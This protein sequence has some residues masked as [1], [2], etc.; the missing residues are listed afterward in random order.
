MPG[1]VG[2]SRRRHRQSA[3]ATAACS[4]RRTLGTGSS[5]R[6][7][8]GVSQPSGATFRGPVARAAHTATTAAATSSTWTYWIGVSSLVGSAAAACSAWASH[9][10][11][12]SAT[13][14]T[15]RRVAATASAWSAAHSPTIRSI[16][17]FCTAKARSGCGRSGASSVRGTALLAQGP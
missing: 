13:T 11:V 16:S 10:L 9:P 6:R 8:V 2:A 15:G 12:P 14:V 1:A 17:A 5:A 3:T 7:A 4:G